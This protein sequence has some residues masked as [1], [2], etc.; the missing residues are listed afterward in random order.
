MSLTG[1][2]PESY[3]SECAYP[4]VLGLFLV[5]SAIEMRCLRFQ[6][7]RERREIGARIDH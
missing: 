2:R 1:R 5:I 7:G 3:A 4:A 6:S